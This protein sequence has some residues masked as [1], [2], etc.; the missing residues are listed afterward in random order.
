MWFKNEVRKVGV[1]KPEL[2]FANLLRSPGIDSQPGGPVLPTLFFRTG[3]PDT[4]GWRNR[5]L[6]IDSCAP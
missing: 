1:W 5:F 6:E 2:V 4:I 3:P